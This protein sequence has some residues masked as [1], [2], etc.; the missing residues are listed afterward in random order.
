[1]LRPRL[2]L[3]VATAFTAAVPL[4]SHFRPAPATIQVADISGLRPDWLDG[5][6]E[7][8]NGRFYIV[9][10]SHADSGF[11]RYDR[12]TRQ[13]A[14]VGTTTGS[15][16]TWSP[17]GRFLAYFSGGG[18][19]GKPF[20]MLLPMDTVTGLAVA[21]ARR[22]TTRPVALVARPFAWSPDS[23]RIAS[24]VADSGRF[25][26]LS[27][28]F[29]GGDA[30]TL[31][32]EAGIPGPILWSPDGRVIYMNHRRRRGDRPETIGISLATGRVTSLGPARSV[33]VGVSPDGRWLAE[34][35]RILH[36][37]L[38]LVE[39]TGAHAA[40][41][42]QLTGRSGRVVPNG[43]SR[44][45][46]NTL[47]GL[48]HVVPSTVQRLSIGGTDIR[49]V[50]PTDSDGVSDPGLA[51]DGRHIAYTLGAAGARRLVVADADGVHPRVV[52]RGDIGNRNPI[53]A[54]DGEHIAYASGT[55]IRLVSV[56]SGGARWLVRGSA[57]APLCSNRNG[58]CYGV[59]SVIAWR[60]DGKALR[61]LER[62]SAAGHPVIAV[63]E[64]G[65]DGSDR[66]LATS[67]AEER[68]HFIAHNDTLV[69][70]QRGDALR[71]LNL[72][73]GANRPLYTG[74][75][76]LSEWVPVATD[77]ASIAVVGEP[78]DGSYNEFPLLISLT[79]GAARAIPYGLG[80]EVS[81]A[82]FF[83]NGRDLILSVCPGCETGPDYIEKWEIVRLP[84]NGDP[85]QILTAPESSF[86]DFGEP[87]ISP[88]G[89][90]IFF[91]AERS[92]NTR[93]VTLSLP[94]P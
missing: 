10:G 6:A 67:G 11:L 79:T 93:L 20:V 58:L 38:Y 72:R 4:T 41:N 21:S 34:Y 8:P 69:L 73:T 54:A 83:P 59:I 57:S 18:L 12:V 22:V 76:R 51:P 23:R 77:G 15:F 56:G 45:R 64:I 35:D 32:S 39:T 29:N 70:L 75:V 37:G 27:V 61:Y 40:H 24:V 2:W 68:A 50:S 1:M 82:Q 85:P 52:D 81:T 80:G 44:V 28:P 19:S 90:S 25:S 84:M 91:E 36:T 46:P 94:T 42:V 60:S 66:V 49:D 78:A 7:S 31:F 16:P 48:E 3:A 9:A 89:R 55:G 43:W 26:I 53:W 62:K 86:K 47:V 14:R 88:D 92:Y 87:V 17:N 13:W 5:G 71:T 74:A 63:H 30:K 33:L 65:L